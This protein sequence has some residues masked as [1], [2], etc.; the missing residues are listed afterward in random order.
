LQG[1][2]ICEAGSSV[3]QLSE[4][5]MSTKELNHF[6]DMLIAVRGETL[7]RIHGLGAALRTLNEPVIE[8]EEEAQKASLSDAMGRLGENDRVKIELIDMALR[9]I[10]AGEYGV[11]E[12]CGDDIA[13]RRL[14]ALPWTRLCV[15]CAREHERRSKESPRSGQVWR[16]DSMM[17]GHTGMGKEL[18]LKTIYESIEKHSEIN[19]KTLAITVRNRAVH[20]E[21]SVAS[22]YER[23]ILL[24]I[25]NEELEISSIVDLLEV[26]ESTWEE[27]DDASPTAPALS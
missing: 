26:G 10:E 21:G 5:N 13:L 12:A 2:W 1:L 7:D 17:V 4:E 18:L 15:D 8:L 23:Q 11:C 24:Q 19:S 3:F 16:S 6:R 22:E 9:K 27:D 14:E 25:L 20:L